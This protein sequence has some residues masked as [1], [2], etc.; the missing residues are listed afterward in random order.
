MVAFAPTGAMEMKGQTSG[1]PQLGMSNLD[2]LIGLMIYD[3][4]RG[5]SDEQV[6]LP[7]V[8][9]VVSGARLQKAWKKLSLTETQK[10]ELLRRAEDIK[11]SIFNDI[12]NDLANLEWTGVWDKQQ[13]SLTRDNIDPILDSLKSELRRLITDY[14]GKLNLRADRVDRILITG[15]GVNIPGI[16]EL[17]RPVLPN[18]RAMVT[19]T[20]TA[21]LLVQMGAAIYASNP[22][23]LSARISNASY[24]IKGT[25]ERPLADPLPPEAEKVL[26]WWGEPK[27]RVPVYE[28]F[29]EAG[30]PLSATSVEREFR[31]QNPHST[32]VVF[33]IFEQ[34]VGADPR[35]I[36]TAK[37]QLPRGTNPEDR[38]RCR[39]QLGADGL[40]HVEVWNPH[41]KRW[42][43]M[44]EVAI[45]I[46]ANR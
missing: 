46:R 14:L 24:G 8:K 38:F 37:Y 20:G 6:R 22:D 1:N 34:L 11:K 26:K 39:F 13:Y 18:A 25:A 3:R 2:Q 45:E 29:V 19:G 17:F 4:T 5:I 21:R 42:E 43:M 40:A 9:A 28:I 32:H 27:M 44:E 33:E 35:V 30:I 31:P 16:A 23:L 12:A 41:F 10:T 7:L 36:Y 15:G